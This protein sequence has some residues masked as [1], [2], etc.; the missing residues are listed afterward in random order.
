MT[1]PLDVA[2]GIVL[3]EAATPG[4][5]I[6]WAGT[7]LVIRLHTGADRNED[8]RICEI[9]TNTYRDQGRHN[10]ALIAWI[11]TNARSLLER[12]KE[13]EA[14]EET[15]RLLRRDWESAEQ[16]AAQAKAKCEALE[17]ERDYWLEESRLRLL[18]AAKFEAE[19]DRLRAEVE[20]RNAAIAWALGYTTFPERQPGQGAYWWRTEL[21][22][23]SG[24]TDADI[25]NTVESPG[26]E[27]TR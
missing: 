19:R 13:C 8:L 22:Q 12:A 20:R 21:R 7:N 25:A 2:A 5:W 26:A 14:A 3:L 17:R 24:I 16:D 11:V 4:P 23:R 6:V 18:Q 27:G 9:S 10:A 1:P 15:I